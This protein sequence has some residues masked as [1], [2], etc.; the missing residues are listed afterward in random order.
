MPDQQE[1]SEP[2]D[3]IH[4][5]AADARQAM[6]AQTAYGEPVTKNGVTV[7]PA[8]RTRGGFGGG[9]GEG[10]G[11][12]GSGSGIGYGMSSRPVGAFVITDDEVSW[13]PA[14]DVNFIFA[15]GCAV[16]ALYFLF[17]WLTD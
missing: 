17:A 6:R 11:G 13:K 16:A 5:A 3:R 12:K 8:A 14:V 9:G 4:R 7:V 15:L 10:D 2:I 1:T